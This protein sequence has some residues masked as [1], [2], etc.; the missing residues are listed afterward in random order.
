MKTAK[1]YVDEINA[2]NFNSPRYLDDVID[3]EGVKEVAEMDLDE[4]RWYITGTKVFKVGD[5]F[6]GVNGPISLKSEEMSYDDVGV[7]CTAFE[8]VAVPSITYVQK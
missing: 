2:L 5:E 8:M 4:H 7:G 1:E 6:F 3:M